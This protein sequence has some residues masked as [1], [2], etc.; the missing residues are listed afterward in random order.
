MVAALIRL[1]LD[2]AEEGTEVLRRLRT[3]SAED[4]DPVF[5]LA[6]PVPIVLLDDT[7]ELAVVFD[8]P[9][10]LLEAEGA[11]HQAIRQEHQQVP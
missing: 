6:T 11:A 2:R 7:Y 4:V 8:P 1:E 9:S 5:V 3:L 10:L